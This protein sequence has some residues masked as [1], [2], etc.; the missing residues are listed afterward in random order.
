M[1]D[2]ERRKRSALRCFRFMTLY[3]LVASPIVAYCSWIELGWWQGLLGGCV[4]LQSAASF[5][6]L[7]RRIK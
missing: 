4:M 2:V 6:W 3:G 5:Y 1:T 7:S